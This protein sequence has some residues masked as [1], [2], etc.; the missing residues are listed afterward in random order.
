MTDRLTIAADQIRFARDYTLAHLE[1]LQADDWFR[2]PSDGVTH[3]AWQVG[4]LAMA[5]YRL[6]QERT[7]GIALDE[8]LIPQ[9]YFSLFGRDSVPSAIPGDYPPADE[10]RAV[11]NRVHRHAMELL[12]ESSIAEADLDS[13]IHGQ[14]KFVRTKSEA[15]LWCGQHEMLHAGQI[16]LI[17]RLIGYAAKW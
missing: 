7:Y 14:H 15:L 16:G 1:T 17:K 6:V 5:Q 8:Q 9:F 11:F 3:I 13:P 2:Q 10:I 12:A 4:H